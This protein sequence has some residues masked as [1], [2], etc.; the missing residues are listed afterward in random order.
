MFS[1]HSLTMSTASASADE[2]I[3]P[4]CSEGNQHRGVKTHKMHRGGGDAQLVRICRE[5]VKSGAA[6]GF[7]LWECLPE[8]LVCMQN[9]KYVAPLSYY[10]LLIMNVAIGLNQS[11]KTTIAKKTKNKTKPSAPKLNA[12]LHRKAMYP[13]LL[14]CPCYASSVVTHKC[15]AASILSQSRL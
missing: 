8:P 5:A 9:K 10:W 3:S 12:F 2:L 4:V 7:Q 6:S 13:T 15:T 11:K 14:C 1:A